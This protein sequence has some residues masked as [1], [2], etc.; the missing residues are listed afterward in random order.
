MNDRGPDG[1]QVEVDTLSDPSQLQIRVEAAR[2]A[3]LPSS[4]SGQQTNGRCN[5]RMLPGRS[6]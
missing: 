4:R 5:R 1:A 2:L 6:G 3:L